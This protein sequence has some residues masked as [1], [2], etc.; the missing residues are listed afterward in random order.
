MDNSQIY[1]SQNYSLLLVHKYIPIPIR[2]IFIPWIIFLSTNVLISQIAN[3]FQG[4]PNFWNSQTLYTP[5]CTDIGFV[6]LF[7]LLF[8]GKKTILWTLVHSFFDT[9]RHLHR[10]TNGW[11]LQLIGLGA[12]A[13]KSMSPR[14]ADITVFPIFSRLLTPRPPHRNLNFLNINMNFTKFKS[15]VENKCHEINLCFVTIEG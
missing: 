14:A 1:L 10:T 7:L 5:I 6:N 12:D 2:H 9:Y 15:F 13:M 3:I 4:I 11:I 8:A